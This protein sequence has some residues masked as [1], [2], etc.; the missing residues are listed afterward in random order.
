M[1]GNSLKYLNLYLKLALSL[2]I[3]LAAAQTAD[4]QKITGD[5]LKFF[6]SKIRPVL[7]RECYSCHSE[8]AGQAKGGL[9]LDTRIR[10]EV[11]GSSGPAV[12]PNDLDESLLWNAINHED[13]VMPPRKKL[14]DRVIADFKTWIEMGAPDPRKSK[15]AKIQS[16]VTDADIRKG[17]KFWSFKKPK[18]PTVPSIDAEDWARKPIDTFIADRLKQESLK[19]SS[20]ADVY[21]FL[22]RLTFDLIGL[23]PSP[24]Q[25]SE[26][27]RAWNSDPD[28]AVAEM[29]EELLASS[30]YGERWGRHWLDVARYAESTGREVNATFPNAWRYRDYVIDA[31]N[32]DKPYDEFVREQIA[33]DLLPAKTDEEWTEH[34]VATGFLAIGPKSLLERN[35]RQFNLDLVDEQ[36]DVSTRVV[37][38][39]SVA[40]ARCHDHKFDPIQ[41]R[42]YYAMAGIFESTTTHYGTFSSARNRQPSNELILPIA[43]SSSLDES[44]SPYVI[45]KLESQKEDLRDEL[46]ELQRKRREQR[47]SKN[48]D[49]KPVINVTDLNRVTTKISA[50]DRK[51]NSVDETGTPHSFCMGVQDKDSPQD[52][53]LLA[54]GE[55]DQ[56][57]DTVPRGVAQVLDRKGLRIK[58]NS[59][60]R[61]ELAKWMASEQNPLTAR[62][63]V[64]RIWLHMFGAGLV[65]S[66]ENFGAT[67]IRPSHPEL[68]DFLAI[69]FMNNDWSVK[70]LVRMIANSRTYRMSSAFDAD[71]YDLDAENVFYW[72][73]NP[74]QL[75]AESLRD[76]MLFVSGQMDSERPQG[77]IVAKAGTTVVR[78]GRLIKVDVNLLTGDDM[79]SMSM[80]DRPGKKRSRRRLR[81]KTY[82]VNQLES[83]RSVYLPIV[84][85][86]VP[87]PL[88]V[89]DFAAPG[90]VVGQRETSNTPSQGL[91]LLNNNF[92]LRQSRKM[93]ERLFDEADSTTERI[94]LAFQYAFGRPATAAEFAAAEEFYANFEVKRKYRR[95]PK[96]SVDLKKLS[97]LTQAI[98]ASAEFRYIN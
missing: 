87:R 55:F 50:I 20:D 94:E 92:V 73:S 12:V 71:S 8:Q 90:M 15:V 51:L 24:S 38:G 96:N 95:E 36:I 77:S 75:D 2:T 80:S 66:P 33:G 17:R 65:K 35:S 86:N 34:L 28:S 23:P 61:L 1:S 5:Q 25:V 47:R 74:R 6:E 84:R 79:E 85:D 67:G 31:F 72:R 98:M 44:L 45:D 97:A 62:V 81:P 22:R 59:S 42:D 37:L 41:Q 32:D 19:P 56:P 9:R 70:E 91:Y 83:F 63:M 82:D 16:T 68:L 48:K 39:V 54:R 10:T 3:A 7:V 76:S 89:F 4:A 69:E 43:D 49:K 53:R 52:A 58:P 26:F 78:D 60:G 40:C 30:H 29:V 18:M 57:V 27:E 64:N 14:S 11:G 88:E 93:A 46:Q 13:F 21:S